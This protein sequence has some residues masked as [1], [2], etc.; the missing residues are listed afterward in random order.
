[1]ILEAVER[2]RKLGNKPM[3]CML[4]IFDKAVSLSSA[5]EG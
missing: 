3:S 4:N 2:I 5:K 1:M